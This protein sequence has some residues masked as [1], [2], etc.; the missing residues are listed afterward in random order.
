MHASDKAGSGWYPKE[1]RRVESW[2]DEMDYEQAEGM[3]QPRQEASEGAER[4]DASV[5]SDMECHESGAVAATGVETPA[6]VG[7]DQG[8]AASGKRGR[9]PR[10]HRVY[11]TMR[12]IRGEWWS[13]RS[14]LCNG[15]V[16]E[17]GAD[18][19]GAQRVC[20]W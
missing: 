15:R 11:R 12:E 14:R 9:R 20:D 10:G 6:G 1:T 3:E 4:S 13:V 2:S 18:F 5:M 7:A 17:V 16:F 19:V 8:G